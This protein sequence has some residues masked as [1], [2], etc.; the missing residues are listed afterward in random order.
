MLSRTVDLFRLFHFRSIH[1]KHRA[2]TE[3]PLF[4]LQITLNPQNE[5]GTCQKRC[6]AKVAVSL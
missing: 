4:S 6:R 1:C 3:S 5:W 2:N